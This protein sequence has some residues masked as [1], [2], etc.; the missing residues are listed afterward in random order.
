MIV[1]KN[2]GIYM[3]TVITEYYYFFLNHHHKLSDYYKNKEYARFSEEEDELEKQ[4]LDLFE[5]KETRKKA[6]NLINDYNDAIYGQINVMQ[7]QM[8]EYAFLSGLKLGM[9]AEKVHMLSKKV[10]S[11]NI[12]DELVDNLK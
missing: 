12:G 9:D 2:G 5:T 7:Q 10:S 11:L 1:S 3:N 6:M 8:F 4:I